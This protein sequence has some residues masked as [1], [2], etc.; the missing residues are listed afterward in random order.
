MV[1]CGGLLLWFCVKTLL[2]LWCCVINI[3]VVM[4]LCNK[5]CCCYGFVWWFVAMVLC[6]NI[7]VAIVLCGGLFAMVLCGGLL[8]WC[9]VIDLALTKVLNFRQASP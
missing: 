2:L 7:A 6:K 4:V 8:L 9:C 3:A 1:L 5:H